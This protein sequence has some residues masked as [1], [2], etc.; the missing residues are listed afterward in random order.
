MNRIQ[1]AA[2]SRERL[3][4]EPGPP[5]EAALRTDPVGQRTDAQLVSLS[6]QDFALLF[7]RYAV[8]IHRYV[9]RRLGTTEADDLVGQTFLIAFERR[10]HYY[11]SSAGALPWLYGIATNLIH[12]RRRDEVRQYRAYSRS[13]PG[14]SFDGA[15]MLAAEVAA[16][17][18]A[19]S[20]SRALAG[21][22]AGLRQADRDILLLF[23]WE[24]LSYPEIAAA[25]DIP[26]GTVRSRLHRARRALRAALGPDF[27]E[28]PDE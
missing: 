6:R 11:E 16:R 2:F 21:V 28:N 17:V 25:L 12:R 24:D 13:D 8:A 15:D 19:Q 23:A 18:D 7:D 5:P 10:Y 22:L 27:Q 1:T 4:P 3:P 26:I 20:A 9:A 14:G